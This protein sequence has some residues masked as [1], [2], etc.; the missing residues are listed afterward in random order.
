MIRHVLAAAALV[1]SAA[2][3][4]A[5]DT[6]NTLKNTELDM[7]VPP[8]PAFAMLG[9]T[10]ETVL[11][12]GTVRALAASVLNGVDPNGTLQSGVAIDVAPYFAAQGRHITL[13]EY[14]DSGLVRF[15]SRLQLSAATAKAADA[16]DDAVRLAGGIRLTFWDRGDYR[17]NQE[18]RRELSVA[19]T[20]VVAEMKKD[21]LEQ[22]PLPLQATAYDAE[23][24]RRLRL[25]TTEIRAR[26][27]EENWNN[28]SLA[29]GAAATWISKT[30][31][32]NAL[33]KRGGAV[34]ASVGYGFEGVRGLENTSQIIVHAR[35]RT[36]DRVP[37]PQTE[38]EFLTQDSSLAGVRLRIG[39]VDTNGSFEAVSLHA[40]PADRPADR[41]TRL[42]GDFEHRLFE[43]VWLQFAIGG[44][45][46]RADDQ[47]RTFVLTNLKFALGSKDE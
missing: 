8:S 18:F 7:S 5:Q 22:S 31:N 35:Y 9:L 16:G 20:D 44:E 36:G 10:P 4:S 23:L 39:A 25:K 27:R 29:A 28:S 17:Q 11:R 32:V 15:L 14:L 3:A 24:D 45:T 33:S 30:G 6:V 34:W 42:V 26:Y 37:D 38:G 19:R 43:N 1:L 46:G 2:D 41:F 12:P 13:Q 21:G 47:R 40:E